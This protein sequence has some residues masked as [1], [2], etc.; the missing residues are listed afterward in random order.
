MIILIHPHHMD[1]LRSHSMQLSDQAFVQ[2]AASYLLLLNEG[3]SLYSDP[4]L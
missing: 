4:E 3:N 1:A 2:F